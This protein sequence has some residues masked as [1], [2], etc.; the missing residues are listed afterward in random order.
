[1]LPPNSRLW[2]SLCAN[3][4]GAASFPPVPRGVSFWAANTRQNS[5]QLSPSSGPPPGWPMELALSGLNMRRDGTWVRTNQ[6]TWLWEADL[7]ASSTP[8]F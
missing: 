5:V 2:G 6:I 3:L 7:Q 8:F 4:A 1:M